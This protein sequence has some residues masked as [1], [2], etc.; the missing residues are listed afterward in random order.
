MIKG[1]TG[2]FASRAETYSLIAT[3][4]TVYNLN[5]IN[6][7]QFTV[8]PKLAALYQYYRITRVEWRLKPLY[9]TWI[10]RGTTGQM[11]YLYFLFDKAGSF[12]TINANQFEQCGAIPQRVDDKTLVRVWKP[13]VVSDSTTTGGAQ[14][15]SQFKTAPWLPTFRTINGGQAINAPDHKGAV[16]YVTKTDPNDIQQYDIDITVTFQ[17]RKPLVTSQSESQQVKAMET[18]VPK[19]LQ[20]QVIDSSIGGSA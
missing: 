15:V 3:A 2:S 16:Y 9:D 14:Y 6:L 5:D 11:P 18:A 13:A 19:E 7:T 12:A 8:A 20:H 17:F 1:D 4:G 10:H